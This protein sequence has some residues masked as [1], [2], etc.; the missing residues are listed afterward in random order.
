MLQIDKIWD[1]LFPAE[2]ERIVRLLIKKVI[3]TPHTIEVQFRS[4]GIEILATEML[5]KERKT[6]A[7]EVAA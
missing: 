1:Q 4:N 2:Q 5:V 7:Q 6:Q 3:V